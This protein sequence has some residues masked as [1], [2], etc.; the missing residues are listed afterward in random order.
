MLCGANIK[1]AQRML[2]HKN[3]STT[4]DRYLDPDELEDLPDRLDQKVPQ[5]A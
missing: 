3:T 1:A 5:G 2:G 4:L